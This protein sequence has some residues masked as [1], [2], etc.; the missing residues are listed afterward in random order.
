MI[1]FIEGCR[2]SG[3][4]YLISEFI[5]WAADPRIEY[6]KFYFAN[7]VQKL[8]LFH[9]D[10]TSNLHYYSLGN[11]MTIMEMNVDPRNKD[12]V[13]VF[14]RAIVSAYVWAVL[15]GR[16]TEPDALSEYKRL[17]DYGLYTNCQTLRVQVDGQ[18]GDSNR[19]KDLWDGAHTTSDE[20]KL[21]TEFIDAGMPW[22]RNEAKENRILEVKNDFNR[23]SIF[24]FREA[25]ST[26]INN[27]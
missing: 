10:R 2:H 11:I 12:K 14:D 27:R 7:H 8:D 13:W 9:L 6:Y 25:C 21:M 19:T 18:T 16:L 3:K 23:A 26:L 5:H 22:L 4:T 20:S 17:L 15:R 24:Q 1:L